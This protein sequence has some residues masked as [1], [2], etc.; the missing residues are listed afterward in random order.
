MSINGKTENITRKGLMAIAEKADI[1]P[2]QAKKIIGEVLRVFKDIED[3]E[4][5]LNEAGVFQSH[6]VEIVR[7]IVL[8]VDE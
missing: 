3:I 4:D 8:Y 5:D 6:V 7:N 1:K 2:N